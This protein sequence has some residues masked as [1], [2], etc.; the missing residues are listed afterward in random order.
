MKPTTI[1]RGWAWLR[2]GKI[3]NG[4]S[5]IK[6]VLLERGRPTP[7][8]KPVHVAII[9]MAEYRAMVRELKKARTKP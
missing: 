3:S 8:A 4:A 9:P 5:S 6:K 7:E 1:G 2:M